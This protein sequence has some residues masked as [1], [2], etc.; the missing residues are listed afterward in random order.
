MENQTSNEQDLTFDV[1]TKFTNRKNLVLNQSKYKTLKLMKEKGEFSN[2][3][4]LLSDQNPIEVKF[5]VY[6]KNMNFK[7]KKEFQGS[8]IKI[9]DEILNY[10]EL[11]ND[12]SAK[13]IPGQ[14]SRVEMKSYPGASLREAILNAICHADYSLP[15]N[16][17]VEFFRDKVRIINPGNVYNSTLEAVLGGVQTFRNPALVNV[18][19]KL[20]FIENYGTGL[21]RIREVYENEELKPEFKVIDRYFFL[22]LPNLNKDSYSFDAQNEAQSDAQNEAQKSSIHKKIIDLIKA[23]PRITRKQTATQIGVSK[24]TIERELLKSND[25]RFIGP[26][27]TGHWEIIEDK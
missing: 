15:S 3:G 12:T 8:I 25:I 24:A 7:I 21:Q 1:L 17:K 27:K 20:G 5:A 6:D 2:V 10:S 14:I 11:F 16:I 4:L 13:I 22:T 26:S 23:N 18:L 9:A 19:Y